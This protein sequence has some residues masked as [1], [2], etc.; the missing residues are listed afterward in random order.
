MPER[1]SLRSAGSSSV[2]FAIDEI[3]VVGE[4]TDQ[5]IDLLE[6]ERRCG[7]ALEEAAHEAVGGE[8]EL[9]GCG[10]GLVDGGGPMLL[11]QGE[12]AQDAPHTG[13]AFPTVDGLAQGPH[14]VAGAAG[15]GEELQRRGGRALG[16]VLLAQAAPAPLLAHVLA[17]QR[18][19][20]RVEDA[21]VDTVPLDLD[22]T[23]EVAW[24]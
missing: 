24:G 17:Q 11:D 1:R 15:S 21:H 22:A 10:A 6:R 16:A 19:G 4:L 3:A 14:V 13:F 7:L 5:G 23:A 8:L 18:A 9:Q 20:A 2:S 12:H